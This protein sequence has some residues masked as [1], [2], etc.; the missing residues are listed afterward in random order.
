MPEWWSYR[1][2]DFL[3]F[4]ARTYYRLFERYNAD[5]W[6]AQILA[7]LAGLALL[8]C[9]L[10]ANA[11]NGRAAAALLCACWLWVAWAFHLE[12]YAAI[13]WAA[14]YFA[15]AFMLEALL[16]L[17][18]GVVRGR[19]RFTQAGNAT[20]ML[21][22][23][24]LCLL[25][26]ALFLQP[27]LGPLL[28]RPWIQVE[29]FGLAPDPTVAVTLGVLL[30]SNRAARVLLPVPVLWSLVSGATLWTMKAPDALLMPLLALPPLLL[31][32]RR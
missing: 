13:N 12:R 4:S 7:L 11:W 6:P 17:W 25:L 15:A 29:L 5:I 14:R 8:A 1:L 26:F 27:L 20:G 24:G 23:A 32:L 18:I 16:L 19:L 28:G 10:R 22:R 3:L 9:V 31:L 21:R 2:S 30:A